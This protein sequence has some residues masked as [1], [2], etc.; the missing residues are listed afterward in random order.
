MAAEEWTEKYRPANLD[1][2]V[3]NDK[4]I[5]ELRA[6][7]DS[8]EQ[9]NPTKKGII[10]SG[11]AGV[12]K[13]SSAL[14]LANEFKWGVIEL[15]AS[16]A[17][18]A[19]AIKRI[20]MVGA[21]HETFTDD[22][23]FFPS[24]K[25]GRKLI[26]LD[27]ADNLFERVK[28]VESVEKDYSD[29]GGKRAIIETISKTSQPIILIV[30]DLY[31]LTRGS[32]SALKSLCLIIKFSRIRKP[33]IRKFLRRIAAKEGIKI[34][35]EALDE[36]A[37]H[38]GG[39]LRSAINDLQALVNPQG[40]IAIQDVHALG[41]RDVKSTI[42]DAVREIFKSTSCKKAKAAVLDLDETPDTVILWIDENLPLEYRRP[43]DLQRGYNYLS[44]ADVFLGRIRRRQYYRLWAY[45]NE[46][47]TAGVALSKTEVYRGWVKYNFPGWL[48]KM[49]RT[50]S[51]R[52][53][54]KSLGGKIGRYSHAS[55][56]A[57][58]TEILPYFKELFNRDHEF[59]INMILKLEFEKEEIALLLDAKPESNK[60]KYLLE[61]LEKHLERP[62]HYIS[63][64]AKPSSKPTEKQA[65]HKDEKE[66]TQRDLFEF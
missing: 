36:L 39:D 17:R 56:S 1:L 16:D 49:S 5:G 43:L 24:T 31:E 22:G 60:V 59:A 37:R 48:L 63:S 18:N 45:A 8:W 47:M 42:F 6:W 21:I 23:E 41:Y 53:L 51:I 38:S 19:T 58:L 20:A 27:E 11:E 54:K 30:N 29:R 15:S 33:T 4:A 25:G 52:Q 61:E 57:V 2:I 34:T 44:R 65:E 55:E 7:A 46:L 66:A 9:G 26:I 40:E 13:T 50:K 3:G 10:I 12:G 14:A 28:Q 62:G 32:G 64:D 35:P